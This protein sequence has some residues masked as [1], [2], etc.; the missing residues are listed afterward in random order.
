MR[1]LEYQAKFVT[2]ELFRLVR[3]PVS[4]RKTIQTKIELGDIST[5]LFADIA[6]IM[7]DEMSIYVC[8]YYKS[9]SAEIYSRKRLI[10]KKV[11]YFKQYYRFK[12]DSS[13]SGCFCERI[14]SQCFL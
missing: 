3:I 8:G 12:R 14:S 10:P 4:M 11:H 9:P 2:I 5:K 1:H 13:V 7:L 6:A